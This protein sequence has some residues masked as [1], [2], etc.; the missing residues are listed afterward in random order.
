MFF[1]CVFCLFF[2]TILRMMECHLNWDI[3]VFFYDYTVFCN[4]M[5]DGDSE[6]SYKWWCGCP[7]FEELM[8][9]CKVVI[10]HATGI[11]SFCYWHNKILSEAGTGAFMGTT[12]TEEITGLENP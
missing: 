12:Y 4:L 6:D 11:F 8:Y 3:S 1:V 7:A 5:K 2:L 10:L 9:A